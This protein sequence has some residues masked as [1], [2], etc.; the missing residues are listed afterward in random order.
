MTSKSIAALENVAKELRRLGNEEYAK[1]VTTPIWFGVFG[2][3]QRDHH[4]EMATAFY[5]QAEAVYEAKGI[6][7]EE[8]R[9]IRDRLDVLQEALARI[10]R[11]EARTVSRAPR[12][13]EPAASP[14]ELRRPRRLEIDPTF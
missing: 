9:D 5:K 6:V 8:D 3:K 13:P 12:Q 2:S 7:Q 4:F 1:A 11:S 10:R 14:P